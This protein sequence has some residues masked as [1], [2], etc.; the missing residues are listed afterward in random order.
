MSA[1]ARRCIGLLA[2]VAMVACG[3]GDAP[4]TTPFLEAMNAGKAYLENKDSAKALEAFDRAVLEM[5]RS[6]PAWRNKARA[7]L[8]ARDHAAALES[9]A[10][11]A[12]LER[13]AAATEYLTGLA[14]ARESRFQ[15]ALGPLEEAVRLDPE[16]PPLRFQLANAY[17]ALERLDEAVEQLRETVR[18]DPLHASAHFKLATFARQ[19]GDREE[20]MARQREFLRLRELQGE[21]ARSAEAL[22]TSRYTLAEAAP[23][24]AG[25]VTA[26]IAVSFRDATEEWFA[27]GEGVVAAAVLSVDAEGKPRVVAVDDDGQLMIRQPGTPMPA[28]EDRLST[29]PGF[30]LLVGNYFD[31]VPEGEHYDPVV[32]ARND[33]VVLSAAGSRFFLGSD[34]GGLEDASELAGLGDLTVESAAWADFEHDGDLDLW[35][36]AGEAG[37]KIYQ[38][39]GDGS[40]SDVS[41]A[42][43]IGLSGLVGALGAVDLDGDIAVD[44]I[45][46][47][48]VTGT[49]VYENQRTGLLAPRPD[50]PGLWPPADHLLIDDVDNDGRPNVLLITSQAGEV[51]IIEGGERATLA[52]GT[53]V[54]G[55]ELIDADN[56]GWLDLAALTESG[57]ALWRN[58]GAAGW[59]PWPEGAGL[60]EIALQ[61]PRSVEAVDLDADGDSDLLIVDDRGLRALANEGGNVHGQLKLNL[62]GTKTN[63]GGIGTHLELR[64]ADLMVSREVTGPVVELG[65]GDRTRLDSVQTLW[66]N[67]VV[68]NQLGVDVGKAPLTIDEKNVA[69][70]SCPFLYVWDG[71]EFRF[72]TDLLGNSPLG[73]SIVRGVPLPA[74]PDEIVAVGPLAPKD[75]SFVFAATSEFRELFYFDDARLLAVDHW[76]G[77]EVHPTDKLMPPP[78][79]KSE[80]W[81]LDGRRPLRRAVSDD[82]KDRT[83]AVAEI[84]GTFSD[85]G[86]PVPPPYRGV[87]EPLATSFDFGPLESDRP[88]VL[89][90]TGWLQYGDAS[91]NIAISQNPAVTAESPRLEVE[92]GGEW[93][94]VDV[95]VGMPAG[96]TKTILVDLA[97]KLP[98]GAGRLRLTTSIELRWDRVAL[99]ER[100]S[101]KLLGVHAIE[102]ASAE[103][104]ERGFSEIRSRHPGHPTTPAF[105][106]VSAQP[107]WRTTPQGWVTR[108]GDVLDLVNRRDGRL[109]ILNAGDAVTLKFDAAA[110]AEPPAGFERSY[111]FYSVGWD[112][113][114]D[115][116]VIAGDSVEPL[117]DEADL[118]GSWRSEYN[119]RWVPSDYHGRR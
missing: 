89:A 15:Q 100:S 113:D 54:L 82:G 77:M 58:G 17:Q 70:G 69:T 30:E 106:E 65:I 91:T 7:E 112:K 61:N 68:D 87:V 31:R 76:P 49:L 11:A 26:P 83:A 33:L 4:P 71:S 104:Y 103:L 86:R 36:G 55:A 110:L 34:D 10:E 81:A 73:L 114:S 3:G 78:Y 57:L 13:S 92:V 20:A 50:P 25:P 23:A 53:A 12:G 79:P 5:P 66:T 116:N 51:V 119:T 32:D 22:E 85:P 27:G 45:A 60:G 8:L 67:G 101:E 115:H 24:A 59:A 56:D 75:G 18:L 48:P 1:L 41:E 16:E 63:A 43:G 29:L 118:E 14:H 46:A 72:V 88:W 74:D 37:A 99:F 44:L 109:A 21:E 111:F 97:G 90:L 102:P 94:P 19:N 39:N 42:V 38:N 47:H 2:L 40:F 28:A 107:P 95:V 117:P 84:D 62:V 93:R 52:L 64:A 96:K 105:A 98:A 9:L 35:L 108:Y 80:V 6:A